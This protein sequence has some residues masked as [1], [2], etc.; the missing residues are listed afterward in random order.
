MAESKSGGF[1]LQFQK[2]SYLNFNKQMDELKK[3]APSKA[4]KMIVRLLYD[5]KLLA[6]QKLKSDRHID[7]SRLRNSIY[8]KTL[9]QKFAKSNNSESYTDKGGKSYSKDFHVGLNENE[10]AIGTNVEYAPAIEF[11]YGP[12]IIEAKN[13]GLLSWEP[14]SEGKV[15]FTN[16]NNKTTTRKYYKDAKGQ[17]TLQKQGRIFA[18]R[19]NHPGFAGDS[20]MHWAM[21]NIDINKRAREF[22]KEL[23]N[24]I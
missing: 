1:T 10:G 24:T 19:V 16:S 3:M 4:F 18:K 6:Q 9:G 12:H 23:L 21:K 13:G 14:K 20:F 15:Q 5:M 11:G 8:I 2:E 22:A 7:T 17:F